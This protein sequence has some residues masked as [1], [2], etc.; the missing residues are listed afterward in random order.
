MFQ[1]C[2]ASV[3]LRKV[4]EVHIFKHRL[5]VLALE[6]AGVL[7]LGKSVLLGVISTIYK[8]CQLATGYMS[9]LQSP[10]TQGQNMRPNRL[11]HICKRNYW[12]F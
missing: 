5:Y 4:G 11:S 12:F 7:I 3:I 2:H 6:Q 9:F 10:G 8:F 1:S